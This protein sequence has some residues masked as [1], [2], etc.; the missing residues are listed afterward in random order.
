MIPK[1]NPKVCKAARVGR[2]ELVDDGRGTKARDAEFRRE[3]GVVK[4]FSYAGGEHTG[5]F[6]S[7]EMYIH[8]YAYYARL[9][10]HYHDRWLGR[11]ARQF[12]WQCYQLSKKERT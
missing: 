8:P 5:P 7:F 3:H 9:P 2:W 12:D 10:R 6:T 4:V 11:L 1:I